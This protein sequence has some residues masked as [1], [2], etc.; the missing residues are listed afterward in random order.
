MKPVQKTCSQAPPS[1]E[2]AR[3]GAFRIHHPSD[4]SK[5]I[6]VRHTTFYFA[7]QRAAT[8][9]HCD[10]QGLDG[11]FLSQKDLLTQPNRIIVKG[12]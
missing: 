8:L 12:T 5:Y 6:L 9:L 10:A 7:R 1:P 2:E 3:V 4:P 11:W